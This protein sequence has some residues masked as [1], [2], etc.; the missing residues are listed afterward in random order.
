MNSSCEV[1]KDIPKRIKY[2]KYQISEFCRNQK[3]IK[4]TKKKRQRHAFAVD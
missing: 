2:E 1:L 3:T 4:I